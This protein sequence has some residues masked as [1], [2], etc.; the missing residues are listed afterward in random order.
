M[1]KRK[2]G[3]A[4]T[5]EKASTSIKASQAADAP[6][7]AGSLMSKRSNVA[8]PPGFH[9]VTDPKKRAYVVALAI[10]GRHDDAA[11][12]A[13]VC[14]K[15]GWNWRKETGDAAFQDA[16]EVARV[17]AGDRMEAEVMRR[18]FDGIEEPVYQGGRMVGTVR[19][20]SDLLA[21]FALKAAMPH[22]Y[23]ERVEH[24]GKDG[25]SL[26]FTLQIARPP[27]TPRLLTDGEADDDEEA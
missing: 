3:R 11:A 1:P 25:E 4:R 7:L 24:V 12:A 16:I 18:A 13:G 19:K 23:R 17:L 6:V 26:T 8:T 10:S 14:L 9:E 20:F 5:H 22:K 27:P 2:H 21:I 15:T